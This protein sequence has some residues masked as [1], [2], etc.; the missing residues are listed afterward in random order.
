[1]IENLINLADYKQTFPIY[2]EMCT[3][4]SKAVITLIQTKSLKTEADVLQIDMPTQGDLLHSK[5]CQGFQTLTVEKLDSSSNTDEEELLNMCSDLLEVE[6]V[7]ATDNLQNETNKKLIS[8]V[9]NTTERDETGRLVMPLTWNNKNCHLLGN[10]YKFSLKVL[11]SN[12]SKLKQNASKL[13]MYNDVFKDQE[14]QGI[15]QRIENVEEFMEDNPNCS[16][17]PHMGVF[18]PDRETTKCRVVLLS[19]LCVK[20]RTSKPVVS[21]NQAMLPGPCLNHKII[22]ALMMLRFDKFMIIFDIKKAFLMIGLRELD[23]NRLMLLWY[24]NV[25]R[26][27]FSLIAYRCTRLSFGLRCSPFILMLALY[28][29][30]ILDPSDSEASATIKKNV[31]NN[32]YMDNGSYSCSDDNDLEKAY[33]EIVSVFGS[34]C[35]ELQQVHSNSEKFQSTLEYES[36]D[37][38]KVVNLLGMEW[39]KVDNTISSYKISLNEEAQ[40]KKSIL[41]TLNSVYDVLNVIAPL[42]LRAKLFMQRLQCDSS[43]GWNDKL[44]D[45]LINEWRNI[46]RQ[47]N[48]SPTISLKRFMGERS[49]EYSLIAF[50]DSSKDAFGTVVYIKDVRTNQKSFLSAKNRLVNS[51]LVKKTIPSLELHAIKFG[52]EVLQDIREG[53]SGEMVVVP[54]KVTKLE[55]Y[56]D[57]MVCLHWLHSYAVKFNKIQKQSVFVVNRLREIDQLCRDHKVTF[58]HI[59]GEQNPADY[60]TRPCSYRLLMKTCYLQGPSFLKES[61]RSQYTDLEVTIPNPMTLPVDEVMEGQDKQAAESTTLSNVT[62]TSSICENSTKKEHLLDTRKYSSFSLLVRVHKCV[63]RFINNIKRNL[64]RNKMKH[65]VLLDD[66]NIHSNA[67]N[68]IIRTEQMIHFPE[69]FEYLDSTEKQIKKLP[70]LVSQLNIFPDTSGVLRVKGKFSDQK[71]MPVLLPK[72]SDPTVLII[73]QTHETL[74]HSGVYF[75]I[76]E[77]EKNFWITQVYS[78]VKMFSR[79]V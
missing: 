79:T 16:F 33:E 53:L 46:A 72:R 40:T 5:N 7:G 4:N 9:L 77:H 76:R 65:H 61:K 17:L 63:K 58:N 47:M 31:Y 13:Q 50:T 28:K 62:V 2:N 39:N 19:N 11:Q 71:M 27:D 18:K 43:L 32:L 36:E 25:E 35:F 34:Y 37:D 52:V 6:A 20:S 42:I 48:S 66:E 29:I 59:A 49:S 8:Y 24:K 74:Y 30:L 22:T 73:R 10:N 3:I 78:T 23:Q 51:G 54:I 70:L 75:T 38:P 67:A 55:V 68:E 45:S 44:S 56:T 12:V 1:M 26:G 57:S 21:H 60:V 41:S 14:K 69:I 15:I 64:N